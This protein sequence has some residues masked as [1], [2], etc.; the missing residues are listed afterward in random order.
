[1]EMVSYTVQR[2]TKIAQAG[3][4]QI[5]SH[6]KIHY[7]KAV[8]NCSFVC[9][10][11][12]N[13]MPYCYRQSNCFG[14]AVTPTSANWWGDNVVVKG[15]N[16]CIVYVCFCALAICRPGISHA[17]NLRKFPFLNPQNTN[18]LKKK[19]HCSHM[20]V[21]GEML[22]QSKLSLQSVTTTCLRKCFSISL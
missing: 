20:N 3:H 18:T 12:R 5:C 7:F 19:Q 14:R 1:M 10:S 11:K 8:W 4:F 15:C 17:R 21:I 2:H 9:R 22:H 13:C 6:G 16:H